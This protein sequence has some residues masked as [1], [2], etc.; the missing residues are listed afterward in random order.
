MAT[1]FHQSFIDKHLWV[2][3]SK[4]SDLTAM[5]N[6]AVKTFEA[7]NVRI[8]TLLI[9]NE[10]EAAQCR[11]VVDKAGGLESIPVELKYGI[12]VEVDASYYRCYTHPKFR[13]CAFRQGPNKY[14]HHLEGLYD[15]QYVKSVPGPYW[16]AFVGPLWKDGG[17]SGPPPA[18]T[19]AVPASSAP[20]SNGPAVKSWSQ[21]ASV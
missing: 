11:A 1:Y 8:S 21:I 16:L 13:V 10:G 2:V 18:P 4:V 7:R 17:T 6:E 15:G 3:E 12:G 19:S 20:V 5:V 14:I 9:C